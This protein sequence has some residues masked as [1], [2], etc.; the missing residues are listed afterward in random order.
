MLDGERACRVCGAWQAGGQPCSEHEI[1]D[2]GGRI[3]A[4]VV[5]PCRQGSTQSFRI[6]SEVHV[7]SDPERQAQRV[8]EEAA[9][10]LALKQRV[11][12]A[13]LR[14][15]LVRAEAQVPEYI[16]EEASRRQE[17]EA[18]RK[19]LE[20]GRTRASRVC[21]GT[22]ENRCTGHCC[23]A[24][25]LPVSPDELRLSYEEW[26]RREEPGSELS[27]EVPTGHT[28]VS[29]RAL[30]GQVARDIHLI[31]PMVRHIGYLTAAAAGA[32]HVNQVDP[33]RKGHWYTCAH[34]DRE[35]QRCGIYAHRPRMCREYP[36]GQRCAYEACTWETEKEHP[37]PR[38]TL[39]VL[40]EERD[41]AGAYAGVG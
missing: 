4:R 24:F 38:E 9:Q 19:V 7:T 22:E 29:A 33:G 31:F 14:E 18:A 36:Y 6:R 1:R 26:M 17:L 40:Q 3:Q 35:A 32:P 25:Y 20:A 11:E 15:V 5:E 37:L 13:E 21:D 8:A 41:G 12:L 10:A 30:Y 16:A 23:E 39:R 34:Y 28:E 27:R 2:P